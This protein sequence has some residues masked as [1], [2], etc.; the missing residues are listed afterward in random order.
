MKPIAGISPITGEMVD[1]DVFKREYEG[2][3]NE[4]MQILRSHKLSAGQAIYA[5]NICRESIDAAM[6]ATT[7]F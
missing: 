6:N 1:G 7:D 4:L 2:I 5:L 3:K